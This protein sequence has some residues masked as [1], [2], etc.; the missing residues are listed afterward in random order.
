MS[1][2]TSEQETVLREYIN[3]YEN[4]TDEENKRGFYSDP[5]TEKFNEFIDR[6]FPNNAQAFY[7]TVEF[8]RKKGY[9]HPKPPVGPYGF[10]VQLT[11]KAL[12]YFNE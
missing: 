11:D 9:F 2:L 6:I 8:L 4:E 10:E 12:N 5:E 3:Y 7:N 1:R